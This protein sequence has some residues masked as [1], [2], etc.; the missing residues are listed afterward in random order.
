MADEVRL[1]N[2]T[3]GFQSFFRSAS[4]FEYGILYNK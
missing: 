4:G 3:D 1:A 2:Q